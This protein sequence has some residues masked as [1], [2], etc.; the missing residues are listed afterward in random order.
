MS[1]EGRWTARVTLTVVVEHAGGAW[2]DDCT[3][4]QLRTQAAREAV[5]RVVKMSIGPGIRIVGTP[6]VD[7]ITVPSGEEG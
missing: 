3:L 5:E 7:A 6:R 2:G 1:A 4:G